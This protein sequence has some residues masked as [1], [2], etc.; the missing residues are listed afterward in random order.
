MSETKTLL[1]T[2]LA[3][4]AKV[5]TKMADLTRTL[6]ASALDLQSH[7]KQAHWNVRGRDFIAIH[8]LFDKVAEEAELHA[9]ELAERAGQLGAS[10][11]GTIRMA[12]KHSQLSEYPLDVASCDE[13]I[14]AVAAS[15][16][17]FGKLLEDGIEKA[18]KAGDAVTA[19]ILTGLCRATDKTLW[20][21]ESHT[22]LAAK[23]VA[24]QRKA[25]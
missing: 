1:P 6:L 12:A 17:T 2:R 23:P 14:D 21:V 25:S 20:F 18:A 15:L 16:A 10:V 24:V 22:I 9:D 13:H 11:E 3:L 7:A 5:R 4:P 8:E 19:D